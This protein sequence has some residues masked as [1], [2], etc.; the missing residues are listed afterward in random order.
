M[1]SHKYI[2]IVPFVNNKTI[3]FNGIT[4][5]FFIVDNP[6][7]SF[8]ISLLTNPLKYITTHKPIIDN[9]KKTR[10]LIDRQDNELDFLRQ[11]R[12]SF[13]KSLEYKTTIIPTYDC[14][15]NCW[16]CIQKHQPTT[17]SNDKLN[18]I[19]K[20]ITTYLLDNKIESY[21][22]SWFGGEPLMQ[23]Q[24]IEELSSSLLQ[25]CYNHDIEFSSA[26]TTNGSLLSYSI[27]EML[28]KVNINYYQ[29]AIDGDM[30]E[31]DK[32]KKDNTHNSSF[33]L[34]LNNIVNLLKSNNNAK[35]T[36]RFNYTPKTLSSKRLVNDINSIIPFE[37]RK[38][39]L[40]DL[41]KVWQIKE[42]QIS[43]DELVR[44]QKDFTQSGYI[45]AT[46]HVFSM[47]YVEKEHYNMIY[48]NGGVEKCDN[49]SMEKLRGH[50]DKTGHIIW[51]DEPLFPKANILSDN[52]I[53]SQCNYY[54]LCYCG[55]PVLREER[56]KEHGHVVCGY[57]QD[58]R[59]FEQRILDYCWRIINNKNI[60]IE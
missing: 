35:I 34:I 49:L 33:K 7:V 21:V 12:N 26:L 57:Q 13:I 16:Y 1:K 8:Y 14:N 17:I 22:L 15:Y 45:L 9:L 25:F 27:I 55:C 18:L 32:V 59:I 48:Y 42:E 23:P 53:C 6:K 44:L 36:L 20:H 56:I 28:K 5:L 58:D 50:I 40:V 19:K 46:A 2:Y 30:L 31:H 39:L 43:I 3:F 4:K 60:K 41:Q 37:L 11:E 10:F 51:N 52:C 24:I 29:I 47:C 54:P 38:R